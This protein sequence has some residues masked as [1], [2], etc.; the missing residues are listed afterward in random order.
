MKTEPTT[1]L[2]LISGSL[3]GLA[4]LSGVTG[5]KSSTPAAAPIV[6]GTD[7][8]AVPAGTDPALAANMAPVTDQ[9]SVAPAPVSGG[10]TTYARAPKARVLG[11]R[12]E[13]SASQSAETYP[14]NESQAY[15]TQ[16]PAQQQGYYDQNQNSGY[17]QSVID[18]GQ[19][20]LDEQ[21]VYAQ[22]PPPPIPTYEQPEL[23]Q[24]GDTWTPGYWNYGSGGYYWVPGY[25]VAPPYAGALWTP[26]YWGYN[27][28]RYRYYHGYWGR[29]I[30]YYGGVNYG[31]GYTGYGYSGGYWNGNNFY[32]NRSVNRV[33]N[34]VINTVYEHN[35]P[36]YNNNHISY[37]GPGGLNVRPR[38]DELAVY[39]EQRLPAMETQRANVQQAAANRSQFFAENHGR[40]AVFVNTQPVN[41]GGFGAQQAAIERQQQ[42]IAA[43]QQQ[44]QRSQQVQAQQQ[45]N[46]QEQQQRSEQ[47]QTQQ[48][49]TLQ[50]QQQAQQQNLRNQQLQQQNT[51][52]QQ[53]NL[54]LQQQHN[55]Q[56]EQQ[57]RTQQQQHTQ[58]LQQQ[59]AQ[60]Q[61]RNLQVQQQQHNAQVEQQQRNAQQ[62]RN[63]QLQ[64]QNAQAQQQRNLEAQQQRQQ[65]QRTA[66]TPAAQHVAPPEQQRAQP[67]Q[68][69]RVQPQRPAPQP[70]TRPQPQTQPRT[71]TRPQPTP[72]PAQHAAPPAA[73]HSA[74]PASRGGEEN[75]G[76]E[77]RP[78]R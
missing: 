69:P 4:M 51:Q 66:S 43:Q 78:R 16:A 27:N 57:Q 74:P 24:A 25:W 49:H 34:R 42:A 2:G 68:Q 45:H 64:Q 30:G 52:A 21:A 18:A 32:Y 8:N 13:G 61:Q 33:D 19:A 59:N 22:Q 55:A 35:V 65:E 14:Q 7:P 63:Q 60:A 67:A 70:E 75:H 38:P 44:L 28:N 54:Q 17:D 11:Q 39:H 40:P 72:A 36:V 77:N 76:G 50:A 5:C 53:R 9:T 6:N 12:A 71:E 58:Q 31:H 1:K 29:H 46:L 41:R 10:Q 47:L 73:Q 15:N 26:G 20:A 56:V 37:N 3:L 62:Q 48:Q 23:T